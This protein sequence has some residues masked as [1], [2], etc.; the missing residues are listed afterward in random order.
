MGSLDQP[1]HDLEPHPISEG[2]IP[3]A[4]ERAWQYRLLM[5]PAQA[6]SICLDILAV[7][8]E[9]PEA[10]ILLILALTDQ[11]SHS[12]L[13]VDAKRVL[14]LVAQLP[15]EYE[16]LYYRGLVA[17]R[18]AR[19]AASGCACWWTTPSSPRGDYARP[20]STTPAWT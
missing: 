11:F 5:E 6:E 1:M 2:A 4:L 19:A 20:S 9:H 14:R 18:R 17:E 12:G 7:N 13:V 16:R 3:A 15:V 8:G 10:R